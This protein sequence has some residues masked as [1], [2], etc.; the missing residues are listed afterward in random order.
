MRARVTHD[1]RYIDEW[2]P[3]LDVGIIARTLRELWKHD[4]AF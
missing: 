4:L 2:S 3:A 1:L